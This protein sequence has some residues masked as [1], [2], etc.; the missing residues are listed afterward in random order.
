MI[1]HLIEHSLKKRKRSRISI[2]FIVTGHYRIAQ[3][4]PESSEPFQHQNFPARP[5]CGEAG[6]A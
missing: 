6:A 1:Q 5:A 3:I 2:G 4:I